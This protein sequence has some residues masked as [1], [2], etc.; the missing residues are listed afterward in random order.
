MRNDTYYVEKVKSALH[1]L[2]INMNSLVHSGHAK[3]TVGQLLSVLIA[4]LFPEVD[5]V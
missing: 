1:F 3:L 4:L 5:H 2:F